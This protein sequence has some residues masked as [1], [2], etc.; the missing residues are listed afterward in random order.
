MNSVETRVTAQSRSLTPAQRDDL[1]AIAA[2]MIPESA[3][4]QGAGRR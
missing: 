1:R 2:M 3:E 4:I